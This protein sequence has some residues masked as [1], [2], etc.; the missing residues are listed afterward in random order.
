[1]KT[2]FVCCTLLF[3]TACQSNKS[4]RPDYQSFITTEKLVA[5]NRVQQFRFQ[6]WQPLDDRYLI[7]NSSQNKS[8]LVK[9]MSFCTELRYAQNIQLKQGMSSSLSAKFDS[10]IVPSQINQECTIDSIYLMNK[11]QKQA[12]LEFDQIQKENK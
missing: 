7:L 12:L 9:L 8:Y 6:G 3:L 4:Y 5:K 10:I 1:M 11:A 2:M